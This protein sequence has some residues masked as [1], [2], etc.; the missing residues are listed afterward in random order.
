MSVSLQKANFW[1]RISAYIF[2][3]LITIML[4]VGIAAAVSSAVGYDSYSDKLEEKYAR[5]GEIYHIDLD[6]TQEQFDALSSAIFFAASFYGYTTE[7]ILAQSP[8]WLIEAC[9]YALKGCKNKI[10]LASDGQ[11]SVIGISK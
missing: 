4:A 3:I 8:A 2:D 11:L 5:Y 6:I 1:K 10:P 7:Y 9:R